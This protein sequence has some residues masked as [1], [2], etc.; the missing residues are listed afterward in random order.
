VLVEIGRQ[1][2]L[3]AFNEALRGAKPGQEADFEV[4]YP[5][6]FGSGGWPGRRRYDVTVKAIKS[7]SYPE[8]DTELPSSSA[9]MR[10]SR[11]SEQAARARGRSQEDRSITEAKRTMLE[12]LI[13]PR[14]P[15]PES[16]VHA[17]VDARLDR[18]LRALAQQGMQ[19]DEMRK[20]DFTVCA[21]HSGRSRERGEASL[22]PGPCRGRR[23]VR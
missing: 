10:A 16:F 2:T 8:R 18:G 12:E 14:F 1:D 19:A 21:P 11:S 20:L 17:A 9:T 6:D 13:G 23:D 5:A 7:K 4:E 22:D 15:V 3:P